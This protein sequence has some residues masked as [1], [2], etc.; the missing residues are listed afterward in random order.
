MF[1]WVH[2]L[3][4]PWRGNQNLA[5]CFE[6]LFQVNGSVGAGPVLADAAQCGNLVDVN[7]GHIQ[8]ADADPAAASARVASASICAQRAPAGKGP[9]GDAD[10]AAASVTRSGARAFRTVAADAAVDD[11]VDGSHQHSPAA[12]AAVVAVPCAA[13]AAR[14]R[15]VG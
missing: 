6:F 13:A 12:I 1:N 5:V 11:Q 4:G 14:C 15:W 2:G 9:G 8:I 7:S 10:G 3:S